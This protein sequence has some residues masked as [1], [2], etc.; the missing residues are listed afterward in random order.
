MHYARMAGHDYHE[1]YYFVTINTAP[2]RNCLSRIVCGKVELLPPGEIVLKAYLQMGADSPEIDLRVCAIMPDHFHAIIVFRHR[3]EHPLG[4]HVRRFKARATRAVRGLSGDA[5][6]GLFEENFHDFISFSGEELDSYVQYVKLNP[7]RWQWKHDHPDFFSKHFALR[8]PRLPR[9]IS[10]TA[11]GDRSLL[12]APWIEPVVVHRRITEEERKAEVARFLELAKSGATLIGGFISPGEKEVAKG[13]LEIA[14]AKVICLL[15]YGL[16]EYK[17]HGVAVRRLA[18]SKT[19]VLS[20]F[21]ESVPPT[22]I[23][24]DNCHLNN[25]WARLIAVGLSGDKSPD[26]RPRGL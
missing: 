16:K 7:I 12:D 22:P 24:Y 3:S 13:A 17:P 6:L 4:W 5:S 15:P 1:G 18:E 8:H 14:G 25:D 10:W 21:P 23:N 9:G 11:I 2:R 20:G 19:L 26:P